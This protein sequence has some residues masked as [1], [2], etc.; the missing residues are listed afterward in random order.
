MNDSCPF[1]Q[2]VEQGNMWLSKCL[3]C[4]SG[5]ANKRA[6]C[7]P[8]RRTQAP[9]HCCRILWAVPRTEVLIVRGGSSD[10]PLSRASGRLRGRRGDVAQVPRTQSEPAEPSWAGP[11]RQAWHKEAGSHPLPLHS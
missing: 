9:G 1:T 4:I 10:S 5:I 2:D 3:V 11:G 6:L 8:R 7:A